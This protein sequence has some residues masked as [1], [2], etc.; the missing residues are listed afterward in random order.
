MRLKVLYIL[1][2]IILIK[3]ILRVCYLIDV[4]YKSVL[5]EINLNKD[6]KF[7]VG[8]LPYNYSLEKE[9]IRLYNFVDILNS[10]KTIKYTNYN[11]ERQNKITIKLIFFKKN[12]VL[13]FDSLL[14]FIKYANKHDIMVGIASMMKKDRK[15]EIDTYLRLLKLGN[16]NIFL[17]LAT[18]HSDIDKIVNTVLNQGGCIRLV[19]GWYN[20]GDVKSWKTVSENYLRNS[21][22]LVQTGKYHILATHD[23][24]ILTKLYGTNGKNMD[25]IEIIFFKFSQKFVEKKIKK[26]PYEIKNKSFYKPYGKICMSFLCNFKKYNFIRIIQRRYLGRVK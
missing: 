24:D 7:T 3:I 19:K 25:N 21:K 15:E 13:N 14:K 12:G 6:Y 18:Y 2:A 23:F 1:F 4:S 5:N 9:V 20:D 10:I 22:K 11:R 17:T 16:N 26:F 8:P